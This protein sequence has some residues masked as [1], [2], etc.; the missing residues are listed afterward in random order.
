M[1]KF[2]RI[3]ALVLVAVLALG[4]FAACS[5]KDDNGDTTVAADDTTAAADGTTAAASDKVYKVVADNSFAPFDFLDEATNTYTGIDMDLLAAIAEDQNF[6]YEVDNC[7]WTAALGNLSGGLADGMIAG[8]TI[9]EERLE[10]YD[11]T[12][13]YFEDGQIMFQKEGGALTSF[14]DL[15]GKK[16]AAKNGTMGAKYAESIKDQYGF[17]IEIFDSSDTVY[18]AVLEGN[19]DAGIEDYSVIN[20]R[21]ASSDLKLATFGEKVNVGPYGLAVLKGTNPELISMFNA[22]LTNIKANGKYAEILAKY[23]M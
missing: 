22:G 10:S 16:I 1:K 9:N 12:D 7:G 3:M 23:G 8:M 11:F 18:A 14:E 15:Q 4:A 5:G 2:I 21:I 13:A 20:Y 19:V 6:K 17:T